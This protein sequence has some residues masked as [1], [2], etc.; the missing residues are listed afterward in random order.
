MAGVTMRA[1]SNLGPP[2]ASNGNAGFGG[3]VYTA[4]S[5][6]TA[7]ARANEIADLFEYRIDRPV[8]VRK[9]ESAMLPFLQDKIKACKLLIYSSAN[10]QHPLKAV[11]LTNSTSK[12]LDEGPITVYD[13]GRTREKRWQIQSR[14]TISASSATASTWEP[15]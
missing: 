3:G 15:A 6:V 10:E 14:R 2:L 1:A 7:I 8:T 13:G 4:N 12:T 5:S 9:N 11:E